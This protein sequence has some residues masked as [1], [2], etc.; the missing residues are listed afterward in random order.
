MV[1]ALAA[2]ASSQTLP[3]PHERKVV[4]VCVA[5]TCHFGRPL[6]AGWIYEPEKIDGESPDPSW[7]PEGTSSGVVIL[8]VRVDERGRVTDACVL[9]GISPRVDT[10]AIAAV[11]TWR[12]EPAALAR[13]QDGKP[14]GTAVPIAMTVT[15][16]I[17]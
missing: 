10:K 1:L 13:P 2:M 3:K 8:N 11:M 14:V 7:L 9:R 5:P 6:A 15:V 16:E 12:Y 4:C 17:K